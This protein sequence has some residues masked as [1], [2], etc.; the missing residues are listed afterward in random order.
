MFR[1]FGEGFSKLTNSLV[2][3]DD[4]QA[5]LDPN[6]LSPEQLVE[7]KQAEENAKAAVA[8]SSHEANAT[9]TLEQTGEECGAIES[10]NSEKEDDWAWD[11]VDSS[12]AS[13]AQAPTDDNGFFGFAAPKSLSAKLLKSATF[14]LDSLQVDTIGRS[15]PVDSDV[16]PVSPGAEEGVE[17]ALRRELEEAKWTAA[18]GFHNDHSLFSL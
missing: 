17:A 6:L 15:S 10:V 18:V 12:T 7:R 3:F 9:S 4:L 8:A 14:N 13:S 2:N 11:K 5:D 1:G 16:V